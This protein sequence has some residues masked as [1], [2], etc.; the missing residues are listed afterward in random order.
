MSTDLNVIAENLTELLQNSVNMASVFYDIFLNPE[1]M[2]VELKQFGYKNS[3][4]SVYYPFG[5]LISASVSSNTIEV[6]GSYPVP[7]GSQ[8][9]IS[10]SEVIDG[11]YTVVETSSSSSNTIIKV[12]QPIK[13]DYSA[14]GVNPDVSLFLGNVKSIDSATKTI[15]A[16]GSIAPPEGSII[17]ISN[18]SGSTPYYGV[19]SSS[20][21]NNLIKIVVADNIEDYTNNITFQSTFIPNRAKDRKIALTGD[22]TPEG[23]VEANVGACYVCT[24]PANQTVWFKA[25]G[26][27]NTGW[28]VVLTE[29]GIVQ[30]LAR[31]LS[32]AGFITESDLEIYLRSNEYVTREDV[33]QQI[34]ESPV[35]ISMLDLNDQASGG[36]VVLGD[37]KGYYLSCSTS[38]GFQLPAVTDLTILH[39]IFV[40]L[41]LESSSVQVTSLGTTNYFDKVTP[42]FGVAGMYDI[43]YEYDNNTNEWVCGV[44]IKGS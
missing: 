12:L 24:D 33:A 37:N 28:Q 39:K 30:E 35:T 14:S 17:I 16:V 21:V 19:S 9:Y 3:I 7:V 29:E 42:T 11:V 4:H 2:D 36:T 23:N 6:S 31:F 22:V 38:I 10:D 34:N 5:G 8:I 13:E 18:L 20:V 41:Y 26:S 1:P 15:Q 27:G 40:Q 44:K 43:I 25:S 32:E